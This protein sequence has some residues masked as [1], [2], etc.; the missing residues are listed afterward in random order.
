MPQTIE[1]SREVVEEVHRLNGEIIRLREE[2]EYNTEIIIAGGRKIE[3]IEIEAKRLIT[4]NADL[5]QLEKSYCRQLGEM[6]RLCDIVNTGL[7][8]WGKLLPG[9]VLDALDEI[10]EYVDCIRPAEG[11]KEADSS[12]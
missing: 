10:M 6:A 4:E 3:Q 5:L 11:K 1:V 7:A 2:N 12:D 9:E 8:K